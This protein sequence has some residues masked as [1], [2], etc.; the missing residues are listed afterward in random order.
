MKKR[1]VDQPQQSLQ[2]V[3]NDVLQTAVNNAPD[4]A[5]DL[6]SSVPTYQS[7]R[8]SLHRERKRNE[9]VLPKERAHIQI[10]DDLKTTLDG[11]DFL[12]A[13]DGGEDKILVFATEQGIARA[14]SAETVFIDGTFYTSPRL[15]CQLFTFHVQEQSKVYPAIFAL[16][17][18]K[19]QRT[20]QRLFGIVKTR[21]EALGLQFAPPKIQSDYE[22]AV[23]RA[24]RLEFPR[25]RLAGCAFHF[26]QCLWRKIQSLGGAAAYREDADIRR[27]LR[28]CAA[29]TFV[30]VGRLDEAWVDMQAVAPVGPM[31]TGF[32]DYF[33]ETW[34]DDVASRFPRTM[35]NHHQNMTQGSIRTNNSLESWHRHLKGFVSSAHPNIF[36][37]IRDLQ[38]EQGRIETELRRL[39]QGQQT[40]PP[41]KRAVRRRN[42]RLEQIK[43]SFDRGEK[44]LL[45]L[46]DACAYA[47]HL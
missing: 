24:V 9:P 10:P 19:S 43:L 35:W 22:Q 39:R 41:A 3:Y 12:Q 11:R 38:A 44:T 36:K 4:Q 34:L 47:I 6:A 20:Y 29:L 46:L 18:D 27:F 15:F 25:S 40:R 42:E 30:P 14:C 8:M 17:P 7:C 23:I 26:G 28:R 2:K 21:A 32:S 16:L 45:E 31:L 5:E 37:L 1:A 33:V 13:D